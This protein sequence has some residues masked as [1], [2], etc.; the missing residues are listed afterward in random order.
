MSNSSNFLFVYGTL[1]P[2]FDNAFS[3]YLRQ[4]AFYTGEGS[5][6]GTLLDLGSYP[7]AVYQKNSPTVVWGT[8][9]DIRKNSET[10]LT[11]LDYYEGVGSE[12]ESPTEY[13]RI[14]VPVRC[15]GTI[16]DCWVYIYNYPSD[17]KAIIQSGD[18][19][20]HLNQL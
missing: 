2:T 18:Y 11:Y 13:V 8:V 3:Q 20:H 6:P 14:I 16:I 7:G 4:R 17:D 19:N 9:Y 10:V 5:F 1:R 15:R 12:F